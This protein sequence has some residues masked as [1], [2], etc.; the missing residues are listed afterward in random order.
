M[1]WSK[2]KSHDEENLVSEHAQTHK[3][4]TLPVTPFNQLASS[5]QL[6][7]MELD[8]LYSYHQKDHASKQFSVKR[9]N[10]GRHRFQSFLTDAVANTKQNVN[11]NGCHVNK[12]FW[13][14][15]YQIT[16]PYHALLFSVRVSCVDSIDF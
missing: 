10:D 8:R 16:A 14:G 15:F 9:K 1:G 2:G 12:P 6:V 4:E 13:W 7:F 11:S 3:K 5:T